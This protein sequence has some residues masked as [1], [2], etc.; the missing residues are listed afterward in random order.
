MTILVA[1]ALVAV[2]AGCGSS[3]RTVSIAKTRVVQA[4]P[5]ATEAAM[6]ECAVELARASAKRNGLP[7]DLVH[8]RCSLAGPAWRCTMQLPL[9]RSRVACA[10][11]VVEKAV[12]GSVPSIAGVAI[13][14]FARCAAA[15]GAL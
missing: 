11:A 6:S 15:L 4:K 8:G 1:L 2:L 12:H 10:D 7:V 9:S 3:M 13:V 5:C 14:P